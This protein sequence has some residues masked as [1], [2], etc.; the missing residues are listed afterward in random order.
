MSMAIE[1]NYSEAAARYIIPGRGGPLGIFRLF[2]RQ[3]PPP[4]PSHDP[5]LPNDIPLANDIPFRSGGGRPT[6]SETNVGARSPDMTGTLDRWIIRGTPST[7]MPPGT[8]QPAGTAAPSGT[9][10]SP[11][12][13]PLPPLQR[14]VIKRKQAAKQR[15]R[16]AALATNKQRLKM[17][18]ST[19]SLK[20]W[21]LIRRRTEVFVAESNIF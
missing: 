8:P 13:V 14:R 4:N 3:L 9:G 18:T 10:A 20:K 17:P 5:P 19:K 21:F 6:N 7:P 1:L 16:T 11:R 2:G 12:Q 15:A